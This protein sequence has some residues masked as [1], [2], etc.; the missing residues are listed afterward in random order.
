MKLINCD[1]IPGQA[2]V[3]SPAQRVP[4]RVYVCRDP[5]L[6]VDE[7]A[8]L[9]LRRFGTG[10][11]TSMLGNTPPDPTGRSGWSKVCCFVGGLAKQ[12]WHGEFGG[13]CPG[14]LLGITHGIWVLRRALPPNR[15]SLTASEGAGAG[16]LGPGR[17]AA[18]V[19]LES[20]LGWYSAGIVQRHA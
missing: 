2:V 18:G 16:C 1:C 3:K 10:L 17:Q 5:L 20:A 12:A 11:Q 13:S 15:K 6:G 7:P 4:L 9:S 8:S 19:S 14:A